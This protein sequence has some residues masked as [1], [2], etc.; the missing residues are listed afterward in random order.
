MDESAECHAA[1]PRGRHV[2]HVDAVVALGDGA[3]PLLQRL[4]PLQ[5][6]HPAALR[7]EVPDSRR[8]HDLRFG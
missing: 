3:A 6:R 4:R 5:Q 1:P 2:E 8:S 7:L